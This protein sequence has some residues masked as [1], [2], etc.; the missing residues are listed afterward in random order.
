MPA[1]RAYGMDQDFYPWSPIVTR[2]LL[3]LTISLRLPGAG[4]TRSCCASICCG[5]SWENG[6]NNPR[7]T[8]GSVHEAQK[9]A[10]APPNLSMGPANRHRTVE[11]R[12]E[13]RAKGGK[14]IKS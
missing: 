12:P 2:P 14:A 11:N 9:P 4:G 10:L 3:R 13:A 1:K 7:E 8:S 5:G 6:G